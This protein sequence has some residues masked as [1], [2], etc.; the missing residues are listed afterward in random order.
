MKRLRKLPAEQMDS[1]QKKRILM[2]SLREFIQDNRGLCIEKHISYTVKIV[3]ERQRCKIWKK[4][5]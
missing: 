1:P 3:T 5:E 2:K 4:D